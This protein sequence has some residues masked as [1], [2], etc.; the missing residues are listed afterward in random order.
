MERQIVISI[1]VLLLGLLA[2][3][4][5]N[6]ESAYRLLPANVR[7]P[8]PAVPF[9]GWRDFTSADG[10]YS[11]KFPDI[12]Q[13]AQDTVGQRL[14]DMTVAERANGTTFLVTRITFTG[15]AVDQIHR[16]LDSFRDE[17]ITSQPGS[18]ITEQQATHVG[19][20][21]ALM[22]DMDNVR[23]RSVCKLFFVNDT[24]F[25]VMVIS[26]KEFYRQDDVDYFFASFALHTLKKPGLP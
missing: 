1:C 17:I 7:E 3:F 14:Y 9:A 15:D 16:S 5:W 12:A 11:V 10:Q 21:P 26:P 20:H 13:T 24:L 4:A 23:A 25:M 18:V 6:I 2:F 19:D 8:M 22:F